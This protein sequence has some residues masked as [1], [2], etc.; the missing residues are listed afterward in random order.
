MSKVIQVRGVPESV[1]AELRKR[2]VLAGTSLSDYVLSVLERATKRPL[3][4]EVLAR[5]QDRPGSGLSAEEILDALKE[6]R[7]S[8]S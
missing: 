8:R 3:T 5:A 1:H 2:A 7:S 6:E 4:A